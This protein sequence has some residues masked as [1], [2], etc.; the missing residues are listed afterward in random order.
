M[1]RDKRVFLAAC[2]PSPRL[3]FRMHTMGVGATDAPPRPGALGGGTR[4][5]PKSEAPA[6]PAPRPWGAVY[7]K[8]RASPAAPA[9]RPFPAR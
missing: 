5:S 4:G 7:K 9:R 2:R 6:T 3:G 1:Q 8:P